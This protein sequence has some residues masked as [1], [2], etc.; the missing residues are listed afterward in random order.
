MGISDLLSQLTR[1]FAAAG[2]EC[3][4]KVEPG[5]LVPGPKWAVSALCSRWLMTQRMSENAP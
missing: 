2:Q 5:G 1:M 3:I 4:W